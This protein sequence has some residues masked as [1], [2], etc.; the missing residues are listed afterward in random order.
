MEEEE[1]KDS[2]RTP[3]DIEDIGAETCLG[4]DEEKRLL[5]MLLVWFRLVCYGAV[6]CLFFISSV[7]LASVATVQERVKSEQV[8]LSFKLTFSIITP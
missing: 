5:L 8:G 2:S 4:K 7:L 3:E 1:K 6:V